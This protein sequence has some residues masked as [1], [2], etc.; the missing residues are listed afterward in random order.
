MRTSTPSV[1]ALPQV[2]VKRCVSLVTRERLLLKHSKTQ[3]RQQKNQSNLSCYTVY[4]N[5]PYASQ[6]CTNLGVTGRAPWLVGATVSEAVRFRSSAM[7][8]QLRLLPY[9]VGSPLIRTGRQATQKVGLIPARPLNLVY[10]SL[11][12]PPDMSNTCVV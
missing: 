2:A 10:D 7:A 6:R 3:Q 9:W 4:S 5:T 12:L 1:N 8:V 11:G